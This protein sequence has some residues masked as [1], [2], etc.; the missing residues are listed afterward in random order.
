MYEQHW[1]HV[2]FVFSRGPSAQAK[3][4]GMQ[5]RRLFSESDLEVFRGG[6]FDP[7]SVRII[8]DSPQPNAKEPTHC[9]Q[10]YWEVEGWWEDFLMLVVGPR[11]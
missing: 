8:E 3:K 4:W 1:K 9:H 11:C 7:G 2:F 10:F 5:G 6:G